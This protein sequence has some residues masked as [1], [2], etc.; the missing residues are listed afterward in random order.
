MQAF[1]LNNSAQVEFLQ[2]RKSLDADWPLN[3]RVGEV[4]I[5]QVLQMPKVWQAAKR[6]LRV[7]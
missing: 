2:E 3:P 4:E 6:D 1:H 5:A 7:L